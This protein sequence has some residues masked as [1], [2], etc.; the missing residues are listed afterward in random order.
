MAFQDEER[1]LLR[2][3]VSDPDGPV[4]IVKPGKMPGMVGAAFARYS[5]SRGG[6]REV[7]L[8]EFI[9]EG[10]LDAEHADVLIERILI[11][12][13][14][15]SVQELESAWL[16]LE[17]I[18]NLATKVVEDRRLS[19]PIEQST[20]YVFYDERDAAGRYRY[21]REPTIM[22]SRLGGRYE[23]VLDS[24]FAVYCGLIE[25]M[26][27]Y[28]E[29]RK[30]LETAQ[31]DIRRDD[32]GKITYAQCAD[33]SERRLF[34]AVWKTD[35]RTKACD[36]IR[37]LLP[38]ATLTNVGVHA[39]GRTFEHMIRHLLSHELPEM[40][41]LGVQ[42]KEA[43][44]TVIRRYVQRADVSPWIIGPREAMRRFAQALIPEAP[45]FTP[46]ARF[47]DGVYSVTGETAAMLF[48]ESEHSFQQ[49]MDAL[50]AD[51]GTLEEIRREY[52]GHRQN[53]RHHSGRALE[54][55]S[56][57][58]FELV[59]DFGIFRDLHRH[60]MLTQQRQMLSTRLGY[61]P[62]P[63]ELIE[64]GFEDRVR[65]CY[66]QSA[67]LYEAIRTELGPVVAQY[68]V[69]FGFNLRV[70]F[71]FSDREAQHVL[72]LRTIPQG[73]K[74]Y[75]RLCQDMYQQ[76]LRHD[77]RMAELCPFLDPNDYDWPR[78]D[79]AARE[80]AKLEKLGGTQ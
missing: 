46:G 30:S 5:R 9:R 32:R 1:E 31:Y 48:P 53:R 65:A 11:E 79:A 40:Q 36:T 69:L 63:E 77:P 49:L 38:A 57:W 51:P 33:E 43:L 47:H 21:L 34:R 15:D 3:F 42:V 7:L 44:S 59:I 64:A 56:R 50:A 13:G 80:A 78:A 71:G 23:E 76:M 22:A 20:R 18:S 10:V 62:I 8:R 19:A 41:A 17:G 58:L 2:E 54:F 61:A 55:G 52:L 60:R 68:A 39:N 14:D 45:E 70:L 16:G 6:F 4:F 72:E 75:R 67:D 35:I 24:I 74:S 73:H 28:F 12:F 29:G 66:D 27:A 25:P 26:K 37:I